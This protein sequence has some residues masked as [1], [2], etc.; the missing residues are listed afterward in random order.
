[1]TLKMPVEIA[2]RKGPVAIFGEG[3]ADE[4]WRL[5]AYLD[6]WHSQIKASEVL[7]WVL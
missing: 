4:N 6:L 7:P 3:R 5:Q 1:M 2:R